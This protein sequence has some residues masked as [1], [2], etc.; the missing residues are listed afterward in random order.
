[1]HNNSY[2][3]FQYNSCISRGICSI[4]PRTSAL[5]TV[6]VLYLKLFAKY[7]IDLELKQEIKNFLLNTIPITI[8]NPEFN[9][10][11]YFFAISNFKKYFPQII[12][13]YKT[14]NV[15]KEHEIEKHTQ[16]I[17]E[18]TSDIIEAIRYGEKLFNRA[19]VKIPQEIRNLYSIMLVITKSL[20]INLLDLESYD[21]KAPNAFNTILNLLSEINIES[22]DSNELKIK[23]SEAC[24]TNIKLM[25]TIRKAQ[26]EKFGIQTERDVSYSTRPNK[27]I[28]VVGSNIRELEKILDALKNEEIDIY[29][30][31]EMM[32][33]HTFPKFSEFKNLKGQ[34]GQG[35][36]NCLLDFAT[37]PGPIIL[38]KHS[39]HNI[40]T[41]YR[42]ML[43]TTDYTTSPKGIIKIQNNN[44]TEVLDAAK[45]SKGFKHGKTCESVSIGYNHKKM[46][47]II[48]EKLETN[49]FDKIFIISSDDYSFE[50]R[51][52]F[53]K[54]I[55]LTPSNILI[56]SFSYN[57]EKENFI[58][59]NTCFDNYSWVRVFEDLKEFNIKTTFFVPKCE[60]DTISQIIYL[61]EIEDSSVYLGKCTPIVLNPSLINTLKNTFGINNISTAKKDLEQILE[62]K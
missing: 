3:S 29:T 41:L 60:R 21:K 4:N 30:H 40:E 44:F 49:A 2:E 31:D 27:A 32:L 14:L 8:F 28:L 1:M 26:E 51:A 52:Y 62:E 39:L 17:F 47:S 25:K 34:F 50:Q 42:G 53:E 57:I 43:F 18:E 19:Q 24:K 45:K 20:S 33:A 56:I 7:A 11:S 22:K 23:I 35:L 6:L 16:A 15:E 46:I 9:D 36:E 61:S 5:Q 48:K 37:F 38:T 55:K 58:H 10:N 54:L 13:E 59:I 12:E